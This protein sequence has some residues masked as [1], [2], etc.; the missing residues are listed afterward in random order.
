MNV[1][2][3]LFY[4]LIEKLSIK[5]LKKKDYYYGTRIFVCLLKIKIVD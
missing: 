1:S 5:K 3:N 4:S 2:L